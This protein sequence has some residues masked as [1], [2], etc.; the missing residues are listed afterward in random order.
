IFPWR[1]NVIDHDGID[2]EPLRFELQT[3][4]FD[5][6]ERRDRLRIVALEWQRG[7]DLEVVESGEPGLV[8][9]RPV[10]EQIADQGLNRTVSR[11]DFLSPGSSAKVAPTS[12]VAGARS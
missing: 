1:F 9:K 2:R 10:E 8:V 7:R 4:F 6:G 12:T 11:H 3:E 5:R